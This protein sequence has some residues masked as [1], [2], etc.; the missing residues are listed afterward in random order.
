METLRKVGVPILLG[1]TALLHAGC[2]HWNQQPVRQLKHRRPPRRQGLGGRQGGRGRQLLLQ[3]AVR[4]R[5]GPRVG[6]QRRD[7]PRSPPGS[8]PKATG[9]RGPGT[10]GA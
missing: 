5:R 9:R 6:A 10:A 4:V 3:P 8:G 2:D 1:L 7:E